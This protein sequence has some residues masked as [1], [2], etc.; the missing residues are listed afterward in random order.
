MAKKEAIALLVWMLLFTSAHLRP[1][2]AVD[3]EASDGYKVRNL[4]T[5]SNYTTIQAAINDPETLPEH[6]IFVEKGIFYE[7]IVVNKSLSVIGENQNGTIIDG[8]GTGVVVL[9]EADNV[10]IRGF[11]VR[12]GSTG[13]Y[14]DHSGTSVIKENSVIENTDG[15]LVR[16]SSNCTISENSV[17]N[18]TNRNTLITNSWNFT[19]KDND[20]YGTGGYG[21]N[22]NASSNGVITRNNVH[23]N[24]F[25][26]IGLLDSN[27]CRIVENLVKNN[28]LFGIWIDSSYYNAIYHNNIVNNWFQASSNSVLNTWNNT[29]EGNYWSDYTGV[30]SGHDGIGD[31]WYEVDSGNIDYYPLMG[32]FHSF[33]TS[34]GSDVNIISNSTVAGFEYIELNDTI[35]ISV[36]NM[37]ASQTFGFCR[38][39]I[40][41]VLMNPDEISVIIDDGQTPVLYHNYALYDNGTHRWIYFTY[42]HSAHEIV[43]VSEFSPVFMLLF[44]MVTTLLTVMLYRRKPN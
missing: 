31:S 19:V 33:T 28:T 8:N 40:P 32:M 25:D 23:E 35:H 5:G 9:V 18:N 36:S 20:V 4:N 37:T 7:N 3:V 15:I 27:N 22:A 11:T 34:L 2:V 21:I 29:M 26:G 44:L 14:V 38:A 24:Y 17:A 41:H 13:I 42:E 10:T 30:D 43:I 1:N 39:C 12:N 6:T 16:F